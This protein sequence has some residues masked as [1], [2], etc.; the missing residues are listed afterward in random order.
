MILI[1]LCHDIN[2]ENYELGGNIVAYYIMLHFQLLYYSGYLGILEIYFNL[3]IKYKYI[4]KLF[5][6]IYIINIIL[7]NGYFY[8]ITNLNIVR[9]TIYTPKFM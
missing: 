9:N 6:I 3:L 7:V 1:C 4:I 5:Y 2:V 8:T